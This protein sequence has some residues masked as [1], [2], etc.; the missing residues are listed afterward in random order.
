MK[1][2]N[3]QNE[4]EKPLPL[5]DGNTNDPVRQQL[6][7][8]NNNVLQEYK[9]SH[10]AVKKHDPIDTPTSTAH[11]ADYFNP[12]AVKEH[13]FYRNKS[14]R[15]VSAYRF[16]QLN[17]I[18]WARKSISCLYPEIVTTRRA[19]LY[20]TEKLERTNFRSNINGPRTYISCASSL[21]ELMEMQREAIG[22]YPLLTDP[23]EPQLDIWPAT[24]RD[25]VVNSYIKTKKTFDTYVNKPLNNELSS[26]GDFKYPKNSNSSVYRNNLKK[27]SK[28]MLEDSSFLMHFVILGSHSLMMKADSMR[29]ME[30]SGILVG[31]TENGDKALYFET[32][33]ASGYPEISASLRHKN[34]LLCSHL[35]LAL[36]LFS[37]FHIRR[38]RKFEDPI[39]FSDSK[40]WHRIKVIR[41]LSPTSE[42]SS[43][44]FEVKLREELSKANVKYENLPHYFQDCSARYCLDNYVPPE[45]VRI[46]GHWDSNPNLEDPD[47]VVPLAP[48][49]FLAGFKENE[50]YK[51]SRGERLPSEF[52]Y[53]QIFPFINEYLEAIEKDTLED[54]IISKRKANYKRQQEA[55]EQMSEDS[56]SHGKKHKKH[57]SKHYRPSPEELQKVFDVVNVLD[58]LRK[59]LVQDIPLIK[60]YIPTVAKKNMFQWS[61]FQSFSVLQN[62]KQ[63]QE[64]G[65]TAEG[66]E[67][68]E[69]EEK[70]EDLPGS[71]CEALSDLGSVLQKL[72]TN[73]SYFAD[74]FPSLN[75]LAS[76]QFGSNNEKEASEEADTFE[77]TKTS[78]PSQEIPE[79]TLEGFEATDCLTIHE[80]YED[81]KRMD[82]HREALV[83]KFKGMKKI[84]GYRAYQRRQN[85]YRLVKRFMA[86]GYELDKVL[87]ILEEDRA[88]RQ[89][90][91]VSYCDMNKDEIHKK[92]GLDA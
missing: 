25:D 60:Q 81:F 45:S 53:E 58:Y 86:S 23:S 30:L 63:K 82:F 64:N 88:S 41:S 90:N 14:P 2:I 32:F 7:A 77:N 87:D 38:N 29:N 66:E 71:V 4:L 5:N 83:A 27:M 76:I 13:I 70:I 21:S 3:F 31:E 57:K 69:E 22:T 24:L 49:K 74:N 37:R 78:T 19:I 47:N 67:E 55:L 43:S 42:F 35:S 84:K 10:H 44:R 59:V 17:Y 91:V 15:T 46:F 61:Q 79:T 12:S 85:I 28:T 8:I 92:Y 18:D 9:D 72:N 51:I 36:L 34:P 89:M 20:M 26:A 54:L 6:D 80:V 50:Q 1:T 73:V 75:H 52:I 11:P 48:M 40:S 56:S 33:S 16:H 65:L 68:E 39:D 62:R